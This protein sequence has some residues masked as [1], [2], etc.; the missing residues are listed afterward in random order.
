MTEKI[1]EEFGKVLGEG[2][3][4]ENEMMNRHTTFRIGGPAD[5]YFEARNVSEVQKAL[6]L[7]RDNDLPYLVVGVGAN[8]LVGDKGI[9]GLVI[10]PLLNEMKVVGHYQ[11]VK[12]SPRQVRQVNESTGHYKAYDEDRYLKF[13]DLEID[14]PAP[15]TLV[16]V[17]AGALLPQ[18]IIWSLE[19]GLT[20]LQNFAGIPA[21]VGGCLYNNIH[22]GTHLFDEFVDEVILL[23]KNGRPARV[24]RDEMEFAYD[25]S[26]LQRTGETV[27]E[28]ILKLSHGDVE[29]ARRVRLEWLKRKLK[30]QPQNDCPGC[31]FKNLTP[32]AAQKINAPTVAAGWV[33]DIGLGLKGTKIAGVK[34]SEKHANFFVNDGTGKASDVIQLIEIC[35]SKAQEKFGLELKEEIQLVGEF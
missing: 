18:L 21:S 5:F 4:R 3:V 7:C 30:V 16:R 2:R 23:D 22:G 13:D 20:G 9:R 25:Q 28:A 1:K 11:P 10:R 35:K 19:Q 15:D 8:L 27:L 34:I 12:E 17:G 29:R 24:P 31:I 6:K 33:I 14:E 26:R 32:E